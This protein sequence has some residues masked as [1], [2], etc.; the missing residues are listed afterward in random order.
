MGDESGAPVVV[1][2]VH[3]PADVDHE[4]AAR[5]YARQR[6]PKPAMAMAR[7]APD[8]V[9]QRHGGDAAEA[10][11]LQERSDVTLKADQPDLSQCLVAGRHDRRHRRVVQAH[12][13]VGDVAQKKNPA[14]RQR[15]GQV[16]QRSLL[17]RQ[18]QQ[19]HPHERGV[20]TAFRCQPFGR[21][22]PGVAHQ[23]AHIRLIG[24]GR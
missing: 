2:A 24:T 17:V 22:L 11:L 1:G 6:V 5:A 20:E 16:G 23:E 10:G 15:R 12:R 13:L 3:Q 4:T 18:V 9:A 14:R 21:Q 8:R 19:E 7:G